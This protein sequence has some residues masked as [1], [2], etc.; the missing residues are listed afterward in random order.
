MLPIALSVVIIGLNE[1]PRLRACIQSVVADLKTF[2]QPSEIIYSD[3]GSTDD[4][5]DLARSIP[6]VRVVQAGR[7][8]AAHARN[9]GWHAAT[10]TII[11]F[12]DG[13]MT[14]EP[15][16]LKR[17]FEAMKDHRVGAVFG[18]LRELHVRTNPYCAAFGLDWNKPAGD[19]ESFGGATMIR[20]DILLSVDG[21]D[22]SLRLG[23]D[24]ELSSRVRHV[25]FLIRSVDAPMATHD[26]AIPNFTTYWKRAV[27]V[28]KSSMLVFMKC[29]STRTAWRALSSIVTLTCLIVALTIALSVPWGLPVLVSLALLRWLRFVVRDLR[30]GIGFNASF[31]HGSHLIIGKIPEAQGAL[32]AC[33]LR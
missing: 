21:Y 1:G 12:F 33:L 25:G 6:G 26:L 2:D 5:I 31:A 20:H 10:G 28:G 23:E 9:A 13:D 8:S 18:T 7:H 16:W 11:Q 27:A 15:G 29:R 4:S 17:G 22:E 19:V 30:T 3:S 32:C 14:V 24:P